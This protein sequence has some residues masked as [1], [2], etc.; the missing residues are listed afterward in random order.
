MYICTQL[1]IM[2]EL[3]IV[4]NELY[5]YTVQY[6]E[7]IYIR[8]RCRYIYTTLSSIYYHR[9]RCCVVPRLLDWDERLIWRIGLEHNCALGNTSVK[10]DVNY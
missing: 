2:N 6:T 9:C 10:L 8:P 5:L 7:G 3:Y 1:D 4:A